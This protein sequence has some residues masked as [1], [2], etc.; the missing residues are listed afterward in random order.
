MIAFTHVNLNPKMQWLD[1]DFKLSDDPI[2]GKLLI[3]GFQ[4]SSF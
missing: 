2:W 4:L 3:S 1:V